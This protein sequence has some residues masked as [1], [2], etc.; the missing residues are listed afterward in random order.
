MLESE[1]RQLKVDAAAI[2]RPHSPALALA[3]KTP[4]ITLYTISIRLTTLGPGGSICGKLIG[5]LVA[6]TLSPRKTTTL[7]FEN[8]FRQ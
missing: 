1:N 8:I 5:T 6:L 3:R 7:A 4:R 2:K